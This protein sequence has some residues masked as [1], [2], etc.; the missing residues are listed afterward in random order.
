MFVFFLLE[1]NTF[2]LRFFC[3][4]SHVSFLDDSPSTLKRPVRFPG[5]IERPQ[6]VEIAGS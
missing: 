2:L 6:G 3:M 5:T 4:A 1:D